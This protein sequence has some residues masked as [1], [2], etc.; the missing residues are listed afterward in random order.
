MHK[1]GIYLLMLG[2]AALVGGVYGL[3]HD[4]IS[5]TFS[6][7]YFTR[8]KFIQFGIP[9]AYDNPRLGAAYV[10]VLATWWMGVL[11]FVFLGLFGFMFKT[12]RDMAVNLSKSFV[13]VVSVSLLTGLLG[14]AYGY[15]Q[16]DSQT[17]TENM[18]W[19]RP[20]V[21]NPVQFV[22]VG[23]M[24]NASYIGGLTGLVAGIVYLIITKIRYNKSLK[25]IGAKK[26]EKREDTHDS[27]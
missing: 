10:G 18:Q 19:V 7:E 15:Y 1:L 3:V 24:H 14:L 17:I 25:Q 23:Y 27:L 13:V 22:R 9:W 4:Q 21:I 11:V 6:Q 26:R 20:G 8:F 12:P 16:I 2:V 5:Y